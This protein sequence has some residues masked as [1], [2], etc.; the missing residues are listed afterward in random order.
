MT[1]P[2][3]N[4]PE[5]DI[6]LPNRTIT[7]G[8]EELEVKEF[9]LI[10]GMKL[11]EIMRPMLDDFLA[12]F[13]NT[14]EPD[15]DVLDGVLARHTQAT[16]QML[17][18]AVNKPVKW[19]FDLPYADGQVLLNEFWRV[20]SGFFTLLL[21]R[22]RAMQQQTAAKAAAEAQAEAERVRLA[23]ELASDGFSVN[24]LPPDTV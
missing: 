2:I 19:V 22:R 3:T 13:Q 23:A 12:A 4:T 21:G 16:M 17:A 11:T 24:S 20:N 7:V 8:G 10:Q 18:L 15:L 5:E 6:I 1:D 14:T 9:T